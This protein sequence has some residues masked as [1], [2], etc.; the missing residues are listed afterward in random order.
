MIF[1]I[2]KNNKKVDLVKEIIK[3]LDDL[4]DDIIYEDDEK[5]I[6][7]IKSKIK[8]RE[9]ILKNLKNGKSN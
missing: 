3:D 2:L 4:Y 7:C 9:E 5:D 8:I 6:E 1:E